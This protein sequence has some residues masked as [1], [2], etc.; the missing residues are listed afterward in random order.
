MECDGAPLTWVYGSLLTRPV[1]RKMD[2][3]RKL[4]GSDSQRGIG[5]VDQ[6]NC[7][8]V[9]VYAMGAEPWLEFVTSIKY[10]EASKQII[11]SNKLIE[12]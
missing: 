3:S 10:D 4:S 12:K 9:Y 7:K 1:D 8:Q 2:Q 11:E 5:I 6:L